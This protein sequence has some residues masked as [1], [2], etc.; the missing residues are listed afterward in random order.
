MV[1]AWR[2]DCLLEWN[3][4]DEKVLPLVFLLDSG[5]AIAN[6]DEDAAAL[7]TLCVALVDEVDEEAAEFAMRKRVRGCNVLDL[8]SLVSL[9]KWDR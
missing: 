8:I 4:G 7:A 9:Y 5:R 2:R 6:E 1:L 3:A